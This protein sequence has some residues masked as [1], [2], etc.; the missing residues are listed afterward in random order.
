MLIP[1]YRTLAKRCLAGDAE[2][3]IPK[4]KEDAQ[5]LMD[6]IAAGKTLP[7]ARAISYLESGGEVAEA[8]LDLIPPQPEDVSRIGITGPPGTGK[9]TLVSALA[10]AMRRENPDKRLGIVAVDPSSPFSGGALLGDRLRMAELSEDAGV[11]IR[12]MASRGALGGLAV[13]TDS[14]CDLLASAGYARLIVETVGVGQSEVDIASSCETTLVVLNPES[15]DS[16]QAIK[17]GLMEVADILVVNKGDHPR[18]QKF[19]NDVAAGLEL[20][21]HSE[22][23]F[24]QVPVV[25]TIAT[26]NRGTAEV[27]GAIEKHQRFLA[28]SGEGERRRQRRLQQR[29]QKLWRAALVREIE[30]KPEFEA[31]LAWVSAEVAK[32]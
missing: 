11:F 8:L 26:E 13:A 19:A 3:T 17:A 20:R 24:W 23:P 28:S 2:A 9:S 6:G 29:I 16:V 31:E 32:R 27:L 14:A 18:A 22:G 21:A 12:S 10:I 30:A 7:L 25:Q 5:T 4:M 1:R 15:G